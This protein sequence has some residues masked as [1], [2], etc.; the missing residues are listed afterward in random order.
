MISADPVEQ[1]SRRGQFQA[2]RQD[3]DRLQAR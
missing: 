2:A 1:L 3:H